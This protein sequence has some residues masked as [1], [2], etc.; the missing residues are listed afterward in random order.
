MKPK[1]NHKQ[2]DNKNLKNSETENK[3]ENSYE[4]FEFD[5]CSEVDYGIEYSSH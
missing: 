2:K 3:I 5:D 1:R 4:E